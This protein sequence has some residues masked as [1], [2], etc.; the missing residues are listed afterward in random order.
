MKLLGLIAASLTVFA[1]SATAAKTTTTTDLL[2]EAEMNQLV[3]HLAELVGAFGELRN[4]NGAHTR[5]R[6][7]LKHKSDARKDAQ[8]ELNTANNE[9]DAARTTQTKHGLVV[10]EKMRAQTVAK[11]AFDLAQADETTAQ[12][13]A[14]DAAYAQD[15]AE[16][17]VYEIIQ[18]F[19]QFTKLQSN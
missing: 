14:D 10:E 7:D 15:Q 2:T 18:K 16:H 6:D 3:M 8:N 1:V 17:D 13:A 5:A 11:E 12:S 9:L 19:T 4:K